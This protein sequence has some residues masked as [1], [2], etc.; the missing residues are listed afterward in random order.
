MLQK[1][2]VTRQLI[3]PAVLF[4]VT[5]IYLVAALGIRPQY[6]EGLVGPSFLPIVISVVMYLG[7]AAVALNIVRA[8]PAADEAPREPLNLRPAILVVAATAI[9]IAVFEPLGYALSTLLYVFALLHVFRMDANLLWRL[10]YAVVITAVFYLLFQ[11]FF[12]VR[13]PTLTEWL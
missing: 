4:V 10:V 11:V 13:L 12:H 7:L 1:P 9:Y 8:T 2:T 6:D 3:L 5:T